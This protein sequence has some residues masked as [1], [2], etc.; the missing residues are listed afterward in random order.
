[1]TVG[2]DSVVTVTSSEAEVFRSRQP[3][4]VYLVGHPAPLVRDTP[5]FTQRGGFLF[6]GRL[7]EKDAPNYEGLSWFIHSIWPRIYAALN[8]VTLTVAG[9]LHPQPTE[10]T[11]PGVRLLGP[12]EDLRPIYAGAR[13]F[14][15]P[16]RFAAGVPIKILDAAAAG[17]PVIGTKLMAKLL[18]WKPGVEIVATDDPAEMANAAIALHD[19]NGRWQSMRVA[20]SNRLLREH[21]EAAFRNELRALLEGGVHSTTLPTEPDDAVEAH[22]VARVNNVWSAAQAAN[23]RGGYWMANPMVR[24]CVNGRASG[25]SGR[26]SYARLVQL[27]TEVGWVLPV[28]RAVSLCCG[29][30]ELE[31][32]LAGLGIAHRILGYDLAESAIGKARAQAA[33]AGLSHLEYEVRDLEREGLGQRNVDLIFAHSGVHH[34]S[35]LE[36][37]FDEVHA[38][39]RPGGIFHLN[40]YVGPDRFQWTDQQIAEINHFLESLPERYRRLPGG[41]LRPLLTRPTVLEML[42]YDPSEAVRSSEI[43]RLVTERFHIIERRPLGGTLLH[44]ALHDIAQN[45]DPAEK[46]DR[47]HLQRLIDREDRL[48]ADSV[49]GSD[50]LVLVAKRKG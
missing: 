34:I 50:F 9:P 49:L 22:R 44:M 40:E 14:V 41:G 30:G 2:V 20:S 16:V 24:A 15:A 11:A 35:R 1:L 37:L 7:L 31:R 19:D 48:I 23:G 39:L 10:L 8:G 46:E 17:L 38:A 25:N 43:E 33:A 18:G 45:F 26:D 3:A 21:S 4:P 27:L 6:V 36:E 29:T 28:E 5:D 32:G 47:I 13:V 12:V 42:K